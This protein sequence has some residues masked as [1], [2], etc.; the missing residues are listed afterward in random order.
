MALQDTQLVIQMSQ[1]PA[2]F[3]GTPQ[4]LANIMVRLMKIVS[5]TGTNF[6]FVGDTEPTSNV[7]P[8]LKNGTQWFVW[9]EDIKRYVPLD[10]SESETIWFQTGAATIAAVFFRSDIVDAWNALMVSTTLRT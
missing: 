7:G 5:P 2:T 8:W 1:I 10:I 6:I 3:Q 4:D 9:D